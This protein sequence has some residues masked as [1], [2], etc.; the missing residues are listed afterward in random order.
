MK[1]IKKLLLVPLML[2]AMAVPCTL[3]AGAES[4]AD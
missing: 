2:A 3:S 4:A 1:K